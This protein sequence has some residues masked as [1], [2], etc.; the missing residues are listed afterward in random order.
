MKQLIQNLRDGKTI[1]TDV[2]VPIA[3]PGTALVKTA[4]SLVS[5]GT[6]RMLVEFA[7]KSVLGK[8]QTRPDLVRKVIQKARHEGVLKTLEAAFNSLDKPVALGYSSAGRIVA[9]GEGIKGFH[10]DD[11]VA[12]AGGGYAVHAEYA[13]VP[14]ILLTSLP[15]EVD[16]E[17]AAF[18]TLGAIALHGFRLAQPQIGERIAIIGLGLVG[19]LTA[20][21][22][23]AAG[24]NVFGVDLDPE[25]ISLGTQ[26][27]ATCI[28]NSDA[29]TAGQTFT[30]G[31]G[32]DAVLICAA[33][34]SNEPVELAARIARDRAYVISIGSV[35]LNIPRKLYY[36][37]ELIFKVSRS[38][39]PGRYDSA[40]EEN[41]HDYPHGYVRWTEGRNF[42]AFIDLL[43][44]GK[45][46]IHQ[47]ITHRFPIERA[48][49][50]YQL[51]TGKK[52]QPY[53][54]ILL[55]YPED[56]PDKS[57]TR[58]IPLFT[59]IQKRIETNDLKL[60]ILGAGNYA[61]AVFLPTIN[62]VGNISRIGIASASGLSAHHAAQRYKFD[63][64]ASSELEI[65][66]DPNINVI[67]I[68]TRH[69]HHARQLISALQ[70]G[71]HVYCEKP[72]AIQASDLEQITSV[73]VAENAPLLMVGFNRRFAPLAMRLKS[74]LEHRS[75][76]L[77]AYYRVNAGYLPPDHWLHDPLQG[78]GRIIG[79]GCHFVDFLTFLVGTPPVEVSA[80]TLHDGGFY[81]QDNVQLSFSFSDGSLGTLSYL[82]NG[83]RSFPKER[84]EVFCDRQVA[85]LDD[86]RT[87]ELIKDGRRKL[88]RSFLRQ[89]KGH[90]KAWEAFITAI[91]SGGPPPIPYDHLLG[92]TQATFSSM[93]ALTVSE[94]ISI[95]IVAL[96]TLEK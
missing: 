78:G 75:E 65:L 32:F 12:C 11:R 67:A 44:S 50:A 47:L 43:A 94:N 95:P 91:R 58:V 19:L 6:E 34:Q 40:Y 80:H 51:I 14:K 63:Y 74:F 30:H 49:E 90:R 37:K 21:I 72:L 81:H 24:C 26:M 56:S 88:F 71:K 25:R 89:D 31:H 16:F 57:G 70:E 4:T 96:P 33:A 5:A 20:K 39:G 79:E 85:V 77:A 48:V 2:P 53:L 3:R 59:S 46:D 9:L 29:E 87:L 83:D 66:N 15:I 8:A 41:G 84:V 38:Y 82:A 27:G 61:T 68:L 23:H 7:K 10:V 17:S 92:V 22:A 69:Q 73:L 45:L 42:E 76:P 18:T 36:E 64:A 62:K 60:G 52:K 54:G 86:F 93:A 35:G 1:V 28:L 55:T 13:V